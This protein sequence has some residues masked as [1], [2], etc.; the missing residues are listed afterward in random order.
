MFM[1]YVLYLNTNLF[2]TDGSSLNA[3]DNTICL[4]ISMHFMN[5]PNN[6]YSLNSH[7]EYQIYR[8]FVS[9]K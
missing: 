9:F 7:Q 4:I 3:E 1:A 5:T 8:L 2:M 6:S